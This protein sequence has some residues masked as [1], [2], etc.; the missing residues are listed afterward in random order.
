VRDHAHGAG[1]LL[2]NSWHLLFGELLLQSLSLLRE[3]SCLL[4]QLTNPEGTLRKRSIDYQ[5]RDKSEEKNHSDKYTKNTRPDRSDA[6][7]RSDLRRLDRHL[8]GASTSS[9]SRASRSST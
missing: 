8:R 4:C 1:A 2:E 7:S 6:L 9:R 5:E 3:L